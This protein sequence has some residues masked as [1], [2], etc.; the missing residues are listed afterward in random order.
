MQ[1]HLLKTICTIFCLYFSVNALATGYNE[2][3]FTSNIFYFDLPAN[4]LANTLLDYASQSK[5]S[6]I[7]VPDQLKGLKSSPV[8]GHLTPETALNL[9]LANVPYAFQFNIDLGSVSIIPANDKILTT[10]IKPS[11]SQKE[12]LEIINDEQLIVTGIRGSLLRAM[13]F[14]YETIGV[15]D[16]ITEEDIGK[17]PDSNLAESLQRLSGVTISY[18][19]NEGNKV[20]VRGFD[21]DFNL[22]LLNGRQMPTSNIQDDTA[23][24][25][26]SFNFADLASE[27]IS[28]VEVHKTS[29][30][31]M[32]TGGIGSV[33]DIKT[34][35]PLDHPD[36]QLTF[37][38]KAVSDQTNQV[39]SDITPEL[40]GLYSSKFQ[41]EKFGLLLSF[42]HQERDSRSETA[43]MKWIKNRGIT[44]PDGSSP[45][46]FLT[47]EVWF[48]E[49]LIL[50]IV[51]YERKRTNAQLVFQYRP[52][53]IISSTLDFTFAELDI[54]SS[55]YNQT[56]FFLLNLSNVSPL[57]Y[58][59]DFTITR[60]TQEG[61]D[62]SFSRF[63]SETKNTNESIGL[64]LEFTPSDSWTINLDAHSSSSKLEPYGAGSFVSIVQQVSNI[65]SQSFNANFDIPHMSYA[66]VNEYDEQGTPISF[67]DNMLIEDFIRNTEGISEWTTNET[68]VDQYQLNGTWQ[69]GDTESIFNSVK[70]GASSITQKNRSTRQTYSNLDFQSFEDTDLSLYNSSPFFRDTPT[71]YFDQFSGAFHT[72]PYIYNFDIGT[73][74]QAVSAR[75]AGFDIED[76]AGPFPYNIAAWHPLRSPSNNPLEDNII[77]E[78]VH[79]VFTQLNLIHSGKYFDSE[80]LIGLRYEK[81]DVDNSSRFSAP[82]GVRWIFAEVFFPEL[83]DEKQTFSKSDSYDDILP[84]I[85]VRLDFNDAFVTRLAYSET[86]TRPDM[87][88]IRAS[89]S[90][91][92]AP[93]HDE[94]RTGFKG[95]PSLK[96]YSAKNY[97]V[98]FEWYYGDYNYASIAF[99][100]KKVEG[101]PVQ[102]LSVESLFG[103]RDI[104]NGP[105][106]N[107]ARTELI[108]N[109]VEPSDE[110]V[111]NL[112]LQTFPPSPDD[113]LGGILSNEDDPLMQWEVTSPINSDQVNIDG[114]ELS[115]Q[116]M[117]GDTGFGAVFNY[118]SID[119][120]AVFAREVTVFETPFPSSGDFFNFVGFYDKNGL[121]VRL[122]FHW[123][124]EF[125]LL[126]KTTTSTIV[127]IYTE[128]YGQWDFLTSYTWDE[129]LTLSLEGINITDEVQRT[130]NS[131]PNRL[132]SA[133][134]FGPRYTIGLRYNY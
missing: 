67:R 117:L 110:N 71:S 88:L 32:P 72:L 27:N 28:S 92:S 37:G 18:S 26:R 40:F 47:E 48:P 20:R 83:S 125:P 103:L 45:D 120:D 54:K 97:D 61:G 6:V 15:A 70:F 51:D 116:Q 66:F 121:E 124:D 12:E 4:D 112:L 5:I 16:S 65:S 73:Q 31:D 105:R 90:L 109:G 63:L 58:D 53:E 64:N 52:N 75:Q 104:Y 38:I 128:S 21:S 111:Y 127:P 55:G 119:S 59:E 19:N 115:L 49:E 7:V 33:I 24:G 86:L 46:V 131:I 8:I 23:V 29:T 99:F 43:E 50:N 89:D 101:Y 81:T 122:A 11:D 106:A 129:K 118:T 34:A 56:N 10:E 123:N 79:S 130:Y 36:T 68:T 42:S 114:W 22:V 17:F 1:K 108:A 39:G 9:L 14:K 25:T 82:I 87:A 60:M 44:Y 133:G 3:N 85:N 41:E 77:E 76:A 93:H 91:T 35:R 78:S 13:D 62:F 126:S 84:S 80:I 57:E 132:D 134:Q 94:T 30:A 95:N 98:A 100:N 96:P 113:E 107:A 69:N 74:A 2:K 102:A